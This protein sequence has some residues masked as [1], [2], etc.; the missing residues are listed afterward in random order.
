MDCQI[1]PESAG[2]RTLPVS[3]KNTVFT[4]TAI[5]YRS[6]RSEIFEMGLGRVLVVISNQQV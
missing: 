5:P 3:G 6:F 4:A 1:I 2:L